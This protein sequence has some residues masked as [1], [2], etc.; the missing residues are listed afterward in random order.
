MQT[1][2]PLIPAI[3]RNPYPYYAVLRD[4]A[5]VKFIPSLQGYAVS[6]WDDVVKTLTEPK[7]FSSSKFWPALLGE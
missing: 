3:T 2:D 7:T 5:P 4:E 6:R 1:Y